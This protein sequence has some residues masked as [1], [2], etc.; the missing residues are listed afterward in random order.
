MKMSWTLKPD[1]MTPAERMD[2][3]LAGRPVDHVGLYPFA[4]GFCAKNTG[5]T[6]E[7]FYADPAKSLEAQIWTQQ[8]FAHDETLKF[9]GACYGAWEFGGE[10]RLPTSE[11]QQAPSVLRH[12]VQSEEDLEKLELPDAKIAGMI[13]WNLEFGKLQQRAGLLCTVTV[14]SPLMI[15]G[16]VCGVDKLSRWMLKKPEL[17]HKALRLA[18]DFGVAVAQLWVDTFG[19]QNVEI[20]DAAPTETNQIISPRQFKQFPLPYLTELHE[21]VLAMGVRY[22]YTHICGEQNLNLPLWVDVPFGDPGIAS[23]GHEVDIAK[24]VEVLGN[25]CIIVGNVEPRVLQT[26]SPTDAYE[27]ARQCIEKGKHAPRGFILG[28][29]CELP[30]MSPAANL[31]AMKKAINDF[32]WYE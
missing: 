29:G 30:P 3:F 5:N 22:V 15:A 21:K 11:F 25:K 9:G 14:G 23:F 31:W 8:M 7:S 19:A 12:P 13:P 17:A 6:L 18:T 32:G 26:G 4:R 10:I 20:R 24:A 28:T 16:N 27:L 2:A 1:R